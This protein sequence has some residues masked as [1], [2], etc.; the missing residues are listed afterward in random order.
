MRGCCTAQEANFLLTVVLVVLV[1]L[2]ESSQVLIVGLGVCVDLLPH[3]CHFHKTHAYSPTHSVDS[4]TYAYSP[5][6][7]NCAQHACTAQL[8]R[9]AG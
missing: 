4:Q 6:H 5:V 3:N 8:G 1:G 9:V 7:A 2:V